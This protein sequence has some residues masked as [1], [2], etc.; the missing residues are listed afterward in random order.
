MANLRRNLWGR[1]RIKKQ[2]VGLKNPALILYFLA[3]FYREKAVVKSKLPRLFG[4]FLEIKKAQILINS[5][6]VSLRIEVIKYAKI[7]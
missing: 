5:L 6:N 1:S 3:K 7:F 2:K 4:K